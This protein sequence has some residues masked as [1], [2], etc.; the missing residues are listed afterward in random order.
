[1]QGRTGHRKG[2]PEMI[3]KSLNSASRSARFFSKDVKAVPPVQG[4]VSPMYTCDEMSD[5]LDAMIADPSL[6]KGGYTCENPHPTDQ[7]E[8]DG[9]PSDDEA[10]SHGMKP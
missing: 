5:M 3:R 1:M 7:T 4:T 2:D 9:N 6:R 8:M 10:S